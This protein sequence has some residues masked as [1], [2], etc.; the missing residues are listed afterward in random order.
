[1]R[2]LI[3]GPHPPSTDHAAAAT[4]AAVRARLVAGDD[5]VTVSPEPSSADRSA[6]L[7]GLVGIARLRRMAAGCDGLYLVLG[8]GVG[9][10]PSAPARVAAVERAA[11]GAL[12]RTVDEAV[13]DVG[14]GHLHRMPG[15]RVGALVLRSGARFVVDDADAVAVLV[16]RGAPAASVSIRDAVEPT[17]FDVDEL[18]WRAER[19]GRSALDDE[20]PAADPAAIEAWLTDRARSDADSVDPAEDERTAA[21]ALRSIAPLTLPAPPSGPRR[22]VGVVVARLTGWLLQPVVD[23]VNR[24]HAAAIDAAERHDVSRR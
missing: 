5:V 24:L 6:T 10:T 19:G 17:A 20:L 21:G 16:A 15:G 1:M 13:V 3:A 7:S 2:W 18:A 8:D 9:P 12:V 14:T 23:H 11:L 4:L 22:A